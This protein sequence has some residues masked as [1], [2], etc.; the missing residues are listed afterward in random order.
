M[1]RMHQR[2]DAGMNPVG[3]ARSGSDALD[4]ARRC[5]FAVVLVWTL[6]TGV[7]GAAQDAVQVKPVLAREGEN[8]VLRIHFEVP[9][10][11]MLYAEQL[12]FLFS[13]QGR[14]EEFQLPHPRTYFEATTQQAR[15]VYAASFD[16]VHAFGT[17]VPEPITLTAH[18][19]GCEGATCFMPR[20]RRWRLVADQSAMELETR[21][22]VEDAPMP[23]GWSRLVEGFTIA[24]K[25][26]GVPE[27]SEWTRFL[28][29]ASSVP[30][31]QGAL[32]AVARSR[33]FLAF[34][35][36][37]FAVAFGLRRVAQLRRPHP[38]RL[39]RG[40]SVAMAFL[41][42]CL[43][44][45]F[46]QQRV[47]SRTHASAS[48][49]EVKGEMT[50]TTQNLL[51][52]ALTD[53]ESKQRPVVLV[54][55]APW[56]VAS[57]KATK[58]LTTEAVQAQLQDFTCIQLEVEDL[59]ASPLRE[60]LGFFSVRTVPAYLV[61]KPKGKVAAGQMGPPACELGQN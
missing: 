27:E 30:A 54:M 55:W 53:A 15:L 22:V 16:A 2:W 46:I 39:M 4:F 34:A 25:G 45:G 7:V 43:V 26:G 5:L 37:S 47:L 29:Q 36:A 49:V 58:L 13:D 42:G 21:D 23:A 51:A 60:L 38:M 10:G 31:G 6:M 20:V 33:L 9:P 44:Y 48:S 14:L 32:E 3:R 40:T 18:Y 1:V 59:Q 19:Q 57:K 8:W 52:Q 61:L 11:Y 35:G 56:S 28:E 50:Q 17:A 41:G 24:G 12:A